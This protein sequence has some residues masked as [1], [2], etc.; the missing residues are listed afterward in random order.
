M[1]YK[2]IIKLKRKYLV[3][4]TIIITI[5]SLKLIN[6]VNISIQERI[7]DIKKEIQACDSRKS[8]ACTYY[9]IRNISK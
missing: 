9:E 6:F 1:N 5:F 2:R 3:I 8:R 7:E 4:L